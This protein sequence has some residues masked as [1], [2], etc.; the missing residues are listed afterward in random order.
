MTTRGRKRSEITTTRWVAHIPLDLHQKLTL[1]LADPLTGKLRYGATSHLTEQLLRKWLDET[2]QN[3]AQT[4]QPP[5][6]EIDTS[7]F[8]GQTGDKP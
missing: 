3:Y 5:Q 4:N 6:V 2:I 7:R 1:L 8:S